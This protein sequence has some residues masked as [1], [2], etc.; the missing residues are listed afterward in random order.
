VARGEQLIAIDEV[1][2]TGS[3]TPP[4]TP[5]VSPTRSGHTTVSLHLTVL[6]RR[7]IARF[8]NLTKISHP[9]LFY[10][11]PTL[12]RD[13]VWLKP[14]T[15][16]I[17]ISTTLSLIPSWESWHPIPTLLA[18]NLLALSRRPRLSAPLL[19]PLARL[20]LVLLSWLKVTRA[21][22][23]LSAPSL[24]VMV[25]MVVRLLSEC[26]FSSLHLLDLIG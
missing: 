10:R 6:L 3:R 17:L 11:A 1:A 24:F 7:S 26:K 13:A 19:P 8:S 14:S 18:T 22:Q 25:T 5:T 16:T 4:A 2:S 20:R 21:R 12:L 23:R 9:S 15:T